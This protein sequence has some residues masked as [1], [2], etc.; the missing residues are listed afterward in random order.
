M[1]GSCR[2]FFE[3][4]VNWWWLHIFQFWILQ[5]YYS[6]T[7]WL[8]KSCNVIHY[9]DGRKRSDI[10]M[11]QWYVCYWT[12][13]IHFHDP[14]SESDKYN[15]NIWQYVS[16]FTSALL[17]AKYTGIRL[18]TYL[19][20]HKTWNSF[21]SGEIPRAHE[22]YIFVVSTDVCRTSTHLI[23]MSYGYV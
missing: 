3:W 14:I 4:V 22:F 1:S 23:L 21:E 18:E 13:K 5:W 16:T 15:I 6:K 20:V 17:S 10:T 12:K 9:L 19:T 8:K 7:K 11:M 2:L